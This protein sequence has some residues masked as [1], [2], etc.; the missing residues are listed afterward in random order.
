MVKQAAKKITDGMYLQPIVV[1]GNIRQIAVDR[2]SHRRKLTTDNRDR[3]ESEA[4]QRENPAGQLSKPLKRQ[5]V[6][7]LRASK[8]HDSAAAHGGDRDP[9]DYGSINH[10]W[11]VSNVTLVI[12]QIAK[13]FVRKS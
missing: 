11:S 1:F 12:P 13:D 3:N 8:D 5:H 6:H 9:D 4:N 10:P 7:C 2:R